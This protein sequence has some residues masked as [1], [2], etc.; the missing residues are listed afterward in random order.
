M[1]M[2]GDCDFD[3][4]LDIFIIGSCGVFFFVID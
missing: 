2:V 1:N 3:D 4:M